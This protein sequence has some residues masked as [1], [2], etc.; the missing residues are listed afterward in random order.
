MTEWQKFK[1]SLAGHPGMPLAGV[2]TIA[3]FVAGY[4]RAGFGFAFVG[5]GIMSVFWIP[6]LI[7]SWTDR[8]L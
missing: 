5:A 1:L 2:F 4:Q 6:V 8:N 7:T 3:G